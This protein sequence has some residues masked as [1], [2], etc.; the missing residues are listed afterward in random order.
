[1][2]PL[3]LL[4]LGMLFLLFAGCTEIASRNNAGESN[5][6]DRLS[7]EEGIQPGDTVILYYW[8]RFEDGTQFDGTMAGSPATFEVGKGMLIPGFEQGLYGL[9]VDDR[10][11]IDVEPAMGYGEYNPAL[12]QEFDSQLLIDANI[13]LEV[14]RKV[15]TSIGGGEIVD[16]NMETNKVT[17]NFNH[18]LAGKKLI[19]EVVIVEIRRNLG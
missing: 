10:T 13:P 12:V 16:V 2:R 17:V 18:P 3:V 8:G 19:F 1:M 7:T 15:D 4:G 9:K 6:L 5:L 11:F 14:G